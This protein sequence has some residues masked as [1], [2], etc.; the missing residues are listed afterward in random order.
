MPQASSFDSIL[1]QCRDL[2]CERVADA[3]TKMLNEADAALTALETQSHDAETKKLYQ[4]TRNKVL[5][6]RDTIVTQFRMRFLREFQERSNKVKKIGDQFA[7]IDLSSLELELVAEDDL[8]E[9]LRFNAM[10][11]K[12]RQYC[13][14]ELVALDQRVGVLIGDADL[15][16]ED[17]PF[18]PEAVCDAYKQ[19]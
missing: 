8:D 6:Q 9:S 5:A 18:T 16:S 17:N 14:E 2:V 10:A 7:E 15:Q 1:E 3:L 19:T 13:D 4:V 11:T 12:V